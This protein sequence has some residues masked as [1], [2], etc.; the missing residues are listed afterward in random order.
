[1]VA[2]QPV[3]VEEAVAHSSEPSAAPRVSEAVA[4]ADEAT[5]SYADE[6]HVHCHVLPALDCRIGFLRKATPT[7]V[8]R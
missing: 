3:A 5:P 2:V 6:V 4:E 7:V 8:Q 1:M